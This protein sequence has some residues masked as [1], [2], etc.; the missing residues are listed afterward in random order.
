M[1]FDRLMRRVW[2]FRAEEAATV[3]VEVVLMAPIMVW[4]FLSTLQF[5]DAYRAE[6]ISTKAALTIADMYSRETGNVNAAFLD[7]TQDLPQYLTLAEN[8]PSF[9]VTVLRWNEPQKKHIRVWSKVRGSYP[10]LNTKDLTKYTSSI[11]LLTNGER[12]I[13]VETWTNY[14]PKYGD[15]ID[16]MRGTG[17][18]P[19]EFSTQ[20]FI[21]PRF[22]TTVCWNST[23]DVTKQKC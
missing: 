17:L 19:I 7:G 9:R 8:S 16:Y 23:T 22:A 4:G 15:G 21:S 5:F 12:V 20:V 2:K 10:V 1:M 13:M 14:Q 18:D 11:P 3:S 6:L